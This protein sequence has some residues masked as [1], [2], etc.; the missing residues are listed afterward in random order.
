MDDT[1]TFVSDVVPKM[2][3]EVLAL[4]RGDLQPRLAL[5]SHSE[6]VT[7][8]GAAFTAAGWG[9]VEAAFRELAVNFSA[10]ESCEYEILSAGASGDL[11]YVVGIER[12]V[13]AAG[14]GPPR[15]YSLRVTTILRREDGQWRIIHRHGDPFDTAA[16]QA[17]QQEWRG[18]PEA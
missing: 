6:P 12:S 15:S 18:D 7:L 3:E 13:A 1:E 4:H 14:A 5:W 10:G 16:R 17:L 9:Q 11:G 2:R 8:F